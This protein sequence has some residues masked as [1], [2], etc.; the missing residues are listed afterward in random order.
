MKTIIMESA[1]R[2][3]YL[4]WLRMFAIIG[5]L[6]FHSAM[7]FAA[8]EGWHIKN[9]ETS[10]LFT[11]FNFW[12]SRFRMPLLF[13]ISGSV[14]YFILLKKSAPKFIKM[15]FHRLIIPLL[16]GMLIVVPPQVYVERLTQGFTGNYLNFYPMIFEGKPYPEGNTSWHHLWFILYLFIYNLLAA[17]LFVLIIKNKEAWQNRFNFLGKGKWVYLLTLPGMIIY[18]SLTLRFPQTN[19]LIHDWSYL[20]YWFV[21]VLVGFICIAFQPLVNSLERNRRLSLLLAFV[22]II[23]INYLRWNNKEP[24]DTIVNWHNDWRTYAV[25]ALYPATAWFWVLAIIGY[26]KKYINRE[27]RILKYINEAVYPFYILHQTIIVILAY[28]V[29]DVADSILSKYV[30]IVAVTFI[31]SMFIYHLIIRQNNILRYLFG[32][33][34]KKRKANQLSTGTLSTSNVLPITAQ[35]AI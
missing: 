26:G 16:F 18:T 10:N 34:P 31:L 2:Q 12:L 3:S 30:F 35:A 17:P 33:A 24:W 19:D 23:G 15:R 21:F 7:P 22:T 8:E 27:H 20:P 32:M 9:K 14:C 6:V 1:N 5:V 28:Y 4:D 13:F 29:V 25:L 11:E